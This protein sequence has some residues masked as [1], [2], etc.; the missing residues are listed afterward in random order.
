[1]RMFNPS[2]RLHQI[3]EDGVDMRV[4]LSAQRLSRGNIRS[5]VGRP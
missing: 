5:T 2:M 1:L 4:G 3:Q